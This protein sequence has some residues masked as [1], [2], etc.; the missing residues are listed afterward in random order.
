MGHD[1]APVS[2]QRKCNA[3]ANYQHPGAQGHSDQGFILASVQFFH[4]GANTRA[5]VL[6]PT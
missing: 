6:F 1:R 2:D 4:K 5:Y 3:K